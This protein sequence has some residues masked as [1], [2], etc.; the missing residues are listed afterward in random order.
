MAR[1]IRGFTSC[2]PH[3]ASPDG[4]RAF[5]SV[6]SC[7]STE[8]QKPRPLKRG[9]A[10]VRLLK[11]GAVVRC[12]NLVLPSRGL[13][14]QDAPDCEELDA[15]ALEEC[16]QAARA[17]VQVQS[18]SAFTGA[19]PFTLTCAK[20]WG[21]AVPM[22]VTCST[23]TA[24]HHIMDIQGLRVTCMIMISAP[25]CRAA[26]RVRCGLGLGIVMIS[27]PPC[28][29]ALQQHQDPGGAGIRPLAGAVH[30]TLDQCDGAPQPGDAAGP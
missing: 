19:L 23:A 20:G 11:E 27:A 5:C 28:R 1:V 2:A 14:G 26:R 16:W 8:G 4:Q 3:Q 25:P 18:H 29:L 17:D 24:V 22:P 10:V 21:R 9:D 30:P 13:H 15:A 7:R 6:C 12:S